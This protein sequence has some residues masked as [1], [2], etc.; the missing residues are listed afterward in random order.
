MGVILVYTSSSSF[1]IEKIFIKENIEHKLIPTPRQY[2]SDCGIS[3]KFFN[4]DI[5]IIKE[6][7]DKNKTEY[8]DIIKL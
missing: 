1:K 7:L 4:S 5:E 3:I 2:S 8:K 6:I